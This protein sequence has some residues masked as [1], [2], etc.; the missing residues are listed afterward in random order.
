MGEVSI[1]FA[2][3][4]LICEAIIDVEVNVVT[5]VSN[6]LEHFKSLGFD[7]GDAI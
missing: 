5:N 4:S 6:I 1:D 3:S 2:S 7:M